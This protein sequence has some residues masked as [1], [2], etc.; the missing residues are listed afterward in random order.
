MRYYITLF[1][2]LVASLHGFAQVPSPGE[3]QSEPI[4]L[5]GATVHIGNGE[6]IENAAVAFS[7]WDH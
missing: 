3:A 4:I 1:T 6:V 2:I 7:R 5:M